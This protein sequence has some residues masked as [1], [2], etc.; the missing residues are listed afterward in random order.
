MCALIL[1]FSSPLLAA[2]VV[3]QDKATSPDAAV[4]QA[5]QNDVKTE[6]S[7]PDAQPKETAQAKPQ[8][9]ELTGPVILSIDVT[10]NKEVVTP[11]IMSVITSKVGEHVD[12]EKLRKDAEA[13][14]ELGFFVATDYKVADKDKGVV[15]TFLVQENPV[16]SKIEFK[17]NTVYKSEK[18]AELLFTKPGAIFNRT[19]FRNDLQRIKEKYQKDGYVMANIADVQIEGDAITVVIV[20][21][22]ISQI[23]IQGNKLTKKYVVERYLKIKEGELFNSNKLRLTLNRLQGVGFFSDVNVNFEPGENPNDVVVII[24][25]EEGKTGRLGFNI[26]YGTQSGF[27]GGISYENFNIGG[28]GLKLNVGFELGNRQEY[29]LSLEQ[30]YLGGKVMAWKVGAYKRTWDDL[31]YYIDN[32]KNFEY[33]RDKKGAYIGFGKKFKEE[34]MYNWYLNLDWHT[35]SNSPNDKTWAQVKD[36]P[37]N[38]ENRQKKARGESYTSVQDDLGDGTYYSATLS[39][40][41]LNID[42]YLPYSKGDVEI[43]N[44]QYG[45]AHIDDSK[46]GDYNYCKYWLEAKTYIPIQNFFKNF[47]EMPFGENADRPMMFAARVMIGSATGDVPYEEMYALGGDTT[48]RGFEDEEFRGED[49]LLGNFELRIPVEKMFSIVAFYDVGRAWRKS[50]STSWGSDIGTAPGFGVRLKTPLGNLRL[51]YANGSEDRFHFGFG[52]MF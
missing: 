22:K 36:L 52:E 1:A 50:D 26:A 24:T 48:L 49:M 10:G 28:K 6:P 29:W 5:P 35:V 46:I 38:E 3:S 12:E 2:D 37:I 13:I 41:R 44:F 14:F 4:S 34:S 43:L 7:S 9:P 30:P 47:F 23:V 42:E 31:Y 8:M 32:V 21:P 16:V 17:G 45:R 40:R 18:L 51:D 27:G 20:E 25:V 33:D 11:H 15:V 39:F 19:F